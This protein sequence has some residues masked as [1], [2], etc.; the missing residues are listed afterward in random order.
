MLYWT[1]IFFV[2]SIVA[3]FLGFGPLASGAAAIAQI[4]FFLFLILFLISLV[5]SLTHRKI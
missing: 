5:A 2:V 1:A 3:A 4:L